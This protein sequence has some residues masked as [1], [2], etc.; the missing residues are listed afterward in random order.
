MKGIITMIRNSGKSG[1]HL[2]Q[3]SFGSIIVAKPIN[4]RAKRCS[5]ASNLKDESQRVAR[6]FFMS[7]KN[8][9]RQP[10]GCR[11]RPGIEIILIPHPLPCLLN[12][13]PLHFLSITTAQ[14]QQINR[15]PNA[16]ASPRRSGSFSATKSSYISMTATMPW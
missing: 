15:N 7:H 1:N 11:V 13:C 8:L 3:G 16:G 4:R 9:L 5:E 6:L 10:R 12:L 14:W 2:G